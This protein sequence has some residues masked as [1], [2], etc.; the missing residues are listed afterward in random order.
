MSD[1]EEFKHNHYVP[2]WYQK[3]FMQEGQTKYHY[4]D[5]KPQPMV[6]NGHRY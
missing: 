3:R 2:E 1:G 6:N 4:L 5:T